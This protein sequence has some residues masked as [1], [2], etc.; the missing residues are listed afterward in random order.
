MDGLLQLSLKQSVL[1]QKYLQVGDVR[2]GEVIQ[3]TVKKLTETCL[4]VSMSRSVDGVIWPNHYAD[5]PLK[6]PGK[7][8]K[9]GGNIKCRVSKPNAAA[10]L[11]VK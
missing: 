1:D 3:G 5:I 6:H 11:A 7:R 10:Y 2:I 8:F 4:F 9:A